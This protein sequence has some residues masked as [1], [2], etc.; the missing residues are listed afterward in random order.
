MQIV[1]QVEQLRFIVA[2]WRRS[3]AP[4]AFVPTMGN[5]H[6]GHIAL[7]NAARQQADKTVVSIFVN[8]TQFGEGEDFASY[9]RTEQEDALKLD[10][11]GVD[12]LF[13][14]TV[15]EMYPQRAKIS[16]SVVGLSDDYCGKSR[17]G[18]FNGVA[19]VVCK[20]FNMVQPDF[21]FFGEKDYQ[22]LAIIRQMVS[23]LNFPVQIR[24]VP[25]VREADGLAMSS[26]NA[27]LNSEQR[28]IAPSLYAA[29]C[30]IRDAILAG[31]VAYDRL[32]NEQAEHL[33]RRGFELD[34]LSV[35]RAEDLLPAQADDHELVI[36]LAA[37]LGRTRLIDNVSVIR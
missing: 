23:D 26:R 13:L 7:V 15:E 36:L 19:T 17:P 11:A 35:I 34:Y 29:L 33:I 21:A 25:I 8:P 24:S 3:G 31:D 28:E 10:A 30:R 6:A 32:A 12:L 5:L 14:P 2:E 16:V 22:Q 9:P 18:H 4:I 27:Y 1:T 37:R 20:L